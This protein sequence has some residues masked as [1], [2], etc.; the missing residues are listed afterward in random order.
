MSG[1]Q[2]NCDLNRYRGLTRSVLDY[3]NVAYWP[4]TRSPHTQHVL[5]PCWEKGKKETSSFGWTAI[6][7]ANEFG[8]DR[9]KVSPLVLLSAVHTPHQVVAVL[10]VIACQPPRKAIEE[11]LWTLHQNRKCFFHSCSWETWKYSVF[12][13][14]KWRITQNKSAL[15]VTKHFNES[16]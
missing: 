9:L 8:V 6:E 15:H 13:P 16:R 5:K 4:W 7:N 14:L 2:T 1:E 11:E 12:F 3:R 10:Q